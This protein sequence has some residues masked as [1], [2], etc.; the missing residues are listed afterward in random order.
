MRIGAHE[1]AEGHLP[2]VAVQLEGHGSFW[3]LKN[4]DGSGALA[5]KEH[6]SEVGEVQL[7]AMFEDSY[8][9]VFADGRI[10]RYGRVIGHRD[11]LKVQP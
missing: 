5:P 9:Q 4:T 11:D 3:W 7:H 1:L 2:P 8:A 10:K 6:C